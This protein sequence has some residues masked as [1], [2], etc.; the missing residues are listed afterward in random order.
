M[1]RKATE[2]KVFIMDIIWQRTCIYSI[3]ITITNNKKRI[4]KA[5]EKW[6]KAWTAQ[7]APLIPNLSIQ[8]HIHDLHWPGI[9]NLTHPKHFLL[10]ASSPPSQPAPPSINGNSRSQLYRENLWSHPLSL[11]FSSIPS[12]ICISSLLQ[13]HTLIFEGWESGHRLARSPGSESIT[14]LIV[15]V[16]PGLQSSQGLTAEAHFQAHSRGCWQASGPHWLLAGD[17]SF[18]LH[19]PLQGKIAIC[20]WI[21]PELAR[22][23]E[24]ERGQLDRSHIL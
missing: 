5:V 7:I 10:P 20:I 12:P 23:R 2:R 9:L 18:L 6:A 16:L 4:N 24:S 21:S 14:R 8:L 11:S 15:K 19:G 1:K 13:R 22:E 17:D 3:W